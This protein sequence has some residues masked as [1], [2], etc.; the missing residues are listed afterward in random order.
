[1]ETPN[2]SKL[3]IFLEFTKRRIL[4]KSIILFFNRSIDISVFQTAKSRFIFYGSQIIY[5]HY[6][7]E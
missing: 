7:K 3:L 4:Q 1:M 6:S 2:K 5:I